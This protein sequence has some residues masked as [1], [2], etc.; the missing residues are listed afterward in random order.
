MDKDEVINQ[1][2]DQATFIVHVQYRQNATWQ[3]QV[4]WAEKKITKNF[5]SALELLKLIDN[6]LDESGIEEE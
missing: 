6:A 5:R 2:G 3:G 1:S 4:V